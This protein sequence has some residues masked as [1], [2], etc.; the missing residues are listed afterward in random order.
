MYQWIDCGDYWE[1]VAPQGHQIWK[2]GRRGRVT[3]S[4]SSGLSG[5]S[6]FK[7]PEEQGKIIAGAI[8]EYFTPDEV[9]RM[10]H[11]TTHE[12]I[13]RN[14]YSDLIQKK[15]IERGLIVPKWDYR[16]GA[17]I[18]GEIINADGTSDTIIEIKCPVKMYRPL[19]Q[20]MDQKKNGWVPPA[21][22]YNHIWKNHL[23]QCMHAM[24]CTGKKFCVYIVYSTSDC[25]I[26]VQKIPFDPDF[27]ANH[28]PKLIT[29]Y[30]QYVVPHLKEDLIMP[31]ACLRLN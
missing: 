8:E 7:T 24:A 20:Y 23:I 3:T 16:L 26:F 19:E 27:W 1:L 29:N 6:R 31:P 15:I 5:D 9:A 22:Y 25:S 11:G 21:N 28:Y 17:S 10:S 2:D 30:N 18:D 14:W 13:C 12:P 4:V